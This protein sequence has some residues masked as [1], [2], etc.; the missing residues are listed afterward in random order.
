MPGRKYFVSSGD[1][2]SRLTAKEVVRRP[3]MV[4]HV[5]CSCDC[6]N[7]IFAKPRDLMA[8]SVRSCGCLNK[9]TQRGR[10][11][12]LNTTHGEARRNNA[13]PEYRTWLSMRGRCYNPSHTVYSEYGGRGITV[14]ASWENSFV[15]FLSD[16]GR[17]PGSDFSIE[18]IDNNGI[19]EKSNCRW[20]TNAE[21]ARNRRSTKKFT[22][23]GLTMCL[24]DWAKK[25]NLP[26]KTVYARVF[27]F[28]WSI[29]KALNLRK[30]DANVDQ[31]A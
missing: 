29:E 9:E 28:G 23:N 7:E 8:G 14:C 10:L 12:S 17:K 13:S 30:E 5:R 21:Q 3:I 19:Y 20:A 16:M 1:R 11:R 25:F 18:R 15:N 27:R 4:E 24:T 22:I 6:G 26:Y 2:F 31:S